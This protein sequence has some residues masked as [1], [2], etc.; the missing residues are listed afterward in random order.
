MSLRLIFRSE[1]GR[2]LSHKYFINKIYN[3]YFNN[4]NTNI[5]LIIEDDINITQDDVNNIPNIINDA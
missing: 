2:F 1:I 4:I 3:E 5:S